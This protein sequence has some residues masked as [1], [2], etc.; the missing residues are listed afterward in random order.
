MKKLSK[1]QIQRKDEIAMK[2]SNIGEG[3]QDA[4]QSFNIRMTAFFETLEELKGRYNEVVEE[5]NAFLEEIH[6]SQNEYID[7]RSDSWRDGDAGQV[8]SDWA[9]EWSITLDEIELECPEPLDEPTLDA[10]EVVRN[11]PEHP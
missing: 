6:N 11:L 2:L 3:I 7:D 8:Y 10:L 1:E 9:G 5:G 4:T